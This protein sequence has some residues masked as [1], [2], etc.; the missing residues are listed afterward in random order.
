MPCFRWRTRG[1]PASR[2][3]NCLIF[4]ERFH[5]VEGTKGRSFEGTGIGLALISELVKLHGGDVR[6]RSKLGSGSGFT[7]SIPLGIQHLPKERLIPAATDSTAVSGA[8]FLEEAQQ[9]LSENGTPSLARVNASVPRARVLVADDN[10]DMLDY[11]RRILESQFEI[12]VVS[13]GVAALAAV[14]LNPPDLVLTDVMMPE[15]DGFGLVRALRADSSTATIPV[16]MLSARAGEESRVEGIQSGVDDYLI[17]PFSAKELLARV[18][19]HLKISQIRKAAERVLSE[20]QERLASELRST[21]RLQ[22]ISA[23]LISEQKVEMLYER[24]IDAAAAIASSDFASI[25]LLVSRQG[26]P[27]KLRLLGFRGADRQFGEALATSAGHTTTGRALRSSK[28]V[29]IADVEN[30]D[31]GLTTD[32]LEIYRK[33][34]VRAIQATPLIARDGKILGLISTCW[35]SPHQPPEHELHLLDVLARQAADLIERSHSQAELRDSEERYRTLFESIEEA[36]CI[37]KRLRTGTAILWIFDMW[38]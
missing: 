9:W 10:A 19:A 23:Q 17:K 7:V 26:Q 1:K 37:L 28:R 29:I 32:R 5:R 31:A 27:G 24:L 36:F 6:V 3:R 12:E 16:I 38:R 34:G 11:I 25:H 20:N 33:A 4:F 8:A 22:E 13:N 21:Q 14:H 2:I 30:D 35:S 18:D 15:L